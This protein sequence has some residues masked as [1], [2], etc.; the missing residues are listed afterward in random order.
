MQCPRCQHA[1]PSHAKFCLECG[2]PV[3]RLQGTGSP[4]ASY[5]DQER[6]LSEA[7][8]QQTATSEILRVIAGSPNDIQPVFDTIMQSAAALCNA[9]NGVVLHFDGEKLH[10]VASTGWTNVDDV[11][12]LYPR[13]P[14]PE[15]LAGR[16]ILEGGVVHI[17]DFT[18]T[19][20]LSEVARGATL[21]PRDP[22]A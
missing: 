7:L 9:R 19:R 16:V 10:F 4:R 5:E 11:R 3:D 8:E 20:H 1:N 6:A 22:P 17:D 15:T 18:T 12:G 14:D 21:A 2:T 13:Q